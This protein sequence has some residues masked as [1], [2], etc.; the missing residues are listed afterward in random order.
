MGIVEHSF[1]RVTP[2]LATDN[3]AP[4]RASAVSV[5]ATRFSGG[6][7]PEFSLALLRSKS[8]ADCCPCRADRVLP[9][10]EVFGRFPESSCRG[11]VSLRRFDLSPRSVFDLRKPAP[12][13]GCL[14]L[15]NASK[16][17]PRRSSH[18]EPNQ[19]FWIE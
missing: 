4:W 9:G 7:P 2:S 3:R 5:V 1:H 18:P 8:V 12:F 10:L 16:V 6:W 15:P 19:L 14:V 11:R 13:R 17:Y